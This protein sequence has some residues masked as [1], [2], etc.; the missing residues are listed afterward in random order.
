[1]FGKATWVV[2]ILLAVGTSGLTVGT[3]DAQRV[4]TVSVPKISVP[5]AP[6]IRNGPGLATPKIT[7]NNVKVVPADRSFQPT[8]TPPT[9]VNSQNNSQPSGN[10]AGPSGQSNWTNNQNPSSTSNG[11]TRWAGGATGRLDK[12]GSVRCRHRGQASN[13]N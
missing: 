6:S 9:G 10:L 11:T 7:G 8:S 2:S 13:C 5:T 1:M 3:A 4:P 12:T